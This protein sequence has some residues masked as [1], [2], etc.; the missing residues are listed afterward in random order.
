MLSQGAI[1]RASLQRLDRELQAAGPQDR[2]Q[3]R[4]LRIAAL[5]S[6]PCP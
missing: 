5:I 6:R 1:R 2:Q 3:A 4:Q